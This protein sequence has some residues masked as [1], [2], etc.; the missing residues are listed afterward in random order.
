MKPLTQEEKFEIIDNIKKAGKDNELDYGEV[1]RS[2][3]RMVTSKDYM[4]PVAGDSIPKEFYE[5]FHSLTPQ[6]LMDFT[7]ENYEDIKKES[8]V[9][10]YSLDMF[11]KSLNESG[12]MPYKA[13]KRKDIDT[14]SEYGFFRGIEGYELARDRLNKDIYMRKYT[15]GTYDIL[16]KETFDKEKYFNYMP[17]KLKKTMMTHIDETGMEPLQRAMIKSNILEHQASYFTSE[18]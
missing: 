9:E 12:I 17:D 3:E 1:I 14:G 5:R 8:N 6:Q 4:E 11:F 18:R 15:D 16:D 7:L 13:M 10:N 2:I